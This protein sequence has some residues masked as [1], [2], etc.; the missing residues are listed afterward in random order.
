M[1]SNKEHTSE[2]RTHLMN[3]VTSVGKISIGELSSVWPGTI[4]EGAF[5]GIEIEEGVVILNGSFISDT[6]D[7]G[8]RLGNNAFVSPKARL[9]GCKIKKGAFIGMDSAVLEGAEVGKEAIVSHDTVVPPGMKINEREVVQGAPAEVVGKVSDEMLQRI[10]KIRG[11]VEWKR[12]EYLYMI[13][14]GEEFDVYKELKRPSE[15]KKELKNKLDEDKISIKEIVD[16]LQ[17][18]GFL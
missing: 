7:H 5:D 6:K 4:L 11:H 13:R 16:Q 8:V 15:I 3:N 9:K 12:K 2:L 1:V 17:S 10:E 14:R 18:D